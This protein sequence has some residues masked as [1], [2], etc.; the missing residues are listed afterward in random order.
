MLARWPDEPM[1][2]ACDAVD[3]AAVPDVLA[4]GRS[5]R[6]PRAR[7]RS[8]LRS[9][10]VRHARARHLPRTTPSPPYEPRRS[11]AAPPAPRS[12]RSWLI[13]CSARR[14]VAAVRG[15][16]GRR[17]R[18]R[19]LGHDAVGRG[20]VGGGRRRGGAAAVRRRSRWSRSWWSRACGRRGRRP[21]R[22]QGA[23][24]APARSSSVD[25]PAS[26]DRRAP[27]CRRRSR[28]SARGPGSPWRL[29]V[30]GWTDGAWRTRG[31]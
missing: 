1:N 21:R 28:R 2:I 26:G 15:G 20:A 8:P 7:A 30:S 18:S 6:S 5:N 13:S 16:R 27:G 11:S 22:G 29:T 17:S 12:A 9:G 23:G 14:L 3:A 25:D 31:A 10:C 24:A 4:D 19:G